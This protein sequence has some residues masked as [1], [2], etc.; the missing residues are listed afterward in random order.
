M[1]HEAFYHWYRLHGYRT[2]GDRDYYIKKGEELEHEQRWFEKQVF[3]E[4]HNHDLKTEQ[5]S[6]IQGDFYFRTAHRNEPDFMTQSGTKAR[7]S[8]AKQPNEIPPNNQT[9][10]CQITKLPCW[11]HFQFNGFLPVT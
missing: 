3:I 11:F 1:D 7:Q 6:S 8:I 2:T 10:F 4:A 5:Q 9:I